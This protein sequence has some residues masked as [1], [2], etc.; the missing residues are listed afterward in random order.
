M[1]E[2]LMGLVACVR[3][4][5]QMKGVRCETFEVASIDKHFLGS[6]IKG[7]AERKAANIS[8]CRQLRW[9]PNTDDEADAGAV[10]DLSCSLQNRSH[11]VQTTPLLAAS[12]RGGR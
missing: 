4:W 2:L 7:R 11:A 10:F 6:R 5:A 3:G 12:Q 9:A 1:N 8:R